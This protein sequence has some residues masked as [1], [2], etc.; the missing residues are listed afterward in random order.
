M[1]KLNSDS[2]ESYD[3]STPSTLNPSL[4]RSN[5]VK[6]LDR[7][8]DRLQIPT[9]NQSLLDSQ[10][11]LEY[12]VDDITNSL[13][14]MEQFGRVADAFGDLVLARV[15]GKLAERQEATRRAAGTKDISIQEVLKSISHLER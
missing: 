12:Q 5:E 15:A 13:Y 7:I 6:M 3:Y 8:G 10:S 1:A 14:K 2:L 4:L 9:I 11:N